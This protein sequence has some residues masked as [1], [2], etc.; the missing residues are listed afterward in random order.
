MNTQLPVGAFLKEPLVQFVLILILYIAASLVVI[1]LLPRGKNLTGKELALTAPQ[2]GWIKSKYP[3]LNISRFVIVA[4][5]CVVPALILQGQ[6][7]TRF[8]IMGSLLILTSEEILEGAFA[9]RTGVHASGPK[10]IYRYLY[11]NN[12]RLRKASYV[13][14]MLGTILTVLTVVLFLFSL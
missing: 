1:L 9:V 10:G 4:L 6:L 14:I 5:T 13:Q 12:P 11:S 3:V 7:G 8:L 2:L